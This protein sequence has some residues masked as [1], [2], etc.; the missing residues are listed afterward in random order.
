[1]PR[2]S[3][4]TDDELGL[5]RDTPDVFDADD[6]HPGYVQSGWFQPHHDDAP[7]LPAPGSRGSIIALDLGEHGPVNA[8]ERIAYP[9]STTPDA[10]YFD[11]VWKRCAEAI[12]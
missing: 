7:P 3:I 11:R 12:Q 4:Y 2:A 10:W 5:T 9:G 1:M 6:R 8:P